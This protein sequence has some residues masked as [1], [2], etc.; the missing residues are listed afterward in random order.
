LSIA[1]E[2]SADL[3]LVLA[4][5]SPRRQ[6]LLREARYTFETV[7]ADID[8]TDHAPGLLPGDLAESL[9]I[10]KAQAVAARRP[11]D[12]V[13]A[14]DTVVAIGDLTLGKPND[15]AD[16]RRMLELLGGTTHVVVT[17]I[18]VVHAAAKRLQ[19][20]RVFSTVQM[21]R[22]SPG[23]ID[24]YIAGG[25]WEGKAGGYGIQDSDPFVTRM[26]GCASNIVGLPMNETREMLSAAG[27]VPDRPR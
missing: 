7:P 22:L 16:A 19:S 9:A 24:R 18:A 11:R 27:I 15:A 26:A 21:R 10:R 2:S 8:E 17:G 13:L 3:R 1:A 23:E 4:S 20:G 5:G 12:V 14:A 25:D 6:Q